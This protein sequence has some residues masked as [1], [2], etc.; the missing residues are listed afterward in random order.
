VE[1]LLHQSYPGAGRATA[2]LSHA[3]KETLALTLGAL[4]RFEIRMG[5]PVI[6]FVDYFTLRQCINDFNLDK[7]KEC[8]KA[9]GR[10]VMLAEPWDAPFTLTRTFCA[11]EVYATLDEHI[12]FEVVFPPEQERKMMEDIHAEGR[13]NVPS[14][15][16]LLSVAEN[17][18]V[19]NA[20]ARNP[21]HKQMIDEFIEN[22]PGFEQTN[23]IVGTAMQCALLLFLHRSNDNRHSLL[24]NG[25]ARKILTKVEP[26]ITKAILEDRAAF[27]QQLLHCWVGEFD[28]HLED[29]RAIFEHVGNPQDLLMS[30]D[31]WGKTPLHIAASR[32]HRPTICWLLSSAEDPEAMLRATDMHPSSKTPL[33][34]IDDM[35]RLLQESGDVGQVG[36]FAKLGV[37]LRRAASRGPTA[38]RNL[39]Q[40]EEIREAFAAW[41]TDDSGVISREEL[42]DVMMKLES[43]M[44]ES[45]IDKLMAVADTNQNG[46][47]EIDEFIDWVLRDGEWD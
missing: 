43:S 24:R 34:V 23:S 14:T 41:D 7:V 15:P 31:Q 20:E 45:D 19:R 13:G 38:L 2:F 44:S 47:I 4:K 26:K 8:I 1:W 27:N 28:T 17:L 22:G 35:L 36:H 10:T 39:Q 33:D 16:K 11:F 40:E 6:F 5:A 37:L 46:T 25:V 18:D 42:K 3:Q 12:A 29:M 21:E 32:G 9:I 30:S